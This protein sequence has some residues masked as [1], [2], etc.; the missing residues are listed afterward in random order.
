MR[1]KRRII[2]EK[3]KNQFFGGLFCEPIAIAILLVKIISQNGN[4]FAVGNVEENQIQKYHWIYRDF[5]HWL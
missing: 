1:H 2:R 3:E 5:C 4:K